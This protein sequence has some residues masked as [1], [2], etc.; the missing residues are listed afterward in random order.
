MTPEA[1]VE[2]ILQVKGLPVLAHPLT[3]AEP[4][5][6]VA[7]LAAVGLVGMEVYYK[8]YSESDVA[9]LKELADRHNLIATGGT[10]Y[11]GLDA[12]DEVMMGGVAVPLESVTRLFALK[13]P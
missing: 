9:R 10:D 2:L 3:I 12:E 4:E 8:D 5:A 6:M 1:A 7:R 13:Q 11:H